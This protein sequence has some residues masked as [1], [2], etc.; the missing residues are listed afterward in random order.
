MHE[1]FANDFYGSWAWKCCRKEFAKS[2]GKLCQRCLAKGII[3][4]GTKKQPL[5]VHHTIPLTP[6]NVKQPEIA[7]NWN[8]LEL[9]C[10]DCHEDERKRK[11]KRWQVDKNGS[12]IAR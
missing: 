1:Q 11:E 3:T 6:E 5:E 10:K 4:A 12:V 7:L 8:Y 9:L 2:K